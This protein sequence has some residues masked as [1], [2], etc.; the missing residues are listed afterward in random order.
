M[1]DTDTLKVVRVDTTAMFP[2][3]PYG[4][5]LIPRSDRAIPLVEAY[6]TELERD[7]AFIH[8]VE[9]LFRRIE[10][11]SPLPKGWY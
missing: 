3:L 7:Q 9:D 5:R 10:Q 11:E 2:D 4:L 6:A 8:H 1:A